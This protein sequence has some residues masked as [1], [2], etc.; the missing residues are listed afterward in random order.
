MV[1]CL[2]KICLVLLAV[3]SILCLMELKRRSKFYLQWSFVGLKSVWFVVLLAV[4]SILCLEIE[5]NRRSK[6]LPA[7]VICW[8]KISLVLLA[9]A[10][11]LYLR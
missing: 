5:L 8:L 2:L 1:I 3:A 9:V 10:S 7:V 6:V 4:A 11:I